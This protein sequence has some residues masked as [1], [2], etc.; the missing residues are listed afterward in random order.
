[1]RF[2]RTCIGIDPQIAAADVQFLARDQRLDLAA[3]VAIA[4][5]QPAVVT[6]AEAIHTM[7]LIPFRETAI[8]RLADIGNVIAVRV[9]RVNDLRRSRDELRALQEGRFGRLMARAWQIPFY[10]HP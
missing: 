9:F 4:H 1:M 8:Q 10:L 2:H 3:A 6:P 7:L 5:I